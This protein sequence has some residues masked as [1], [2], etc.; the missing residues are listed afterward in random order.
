MLGP[1]RCMR[2]RRLAPPDSVLAHNGLHYLVGR[3]LEVHRRARVVPAAP[4]Y[5]DVPVPPPEDLGDSFSR[6][7]TQLPYQHYL[8]ELFAQHPEFV[9]RYAL[10]ELRVQRLRSREEGR[11]APPEG[12][13]RTG[14]VV[15]WVPARWGVEFDITLSTPRRTPYRPTPADQAVVS[16]WLSEEFGPPRAAGEHINRSV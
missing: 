12:G 13:L 7:P 6:L 15:E 5:I 16:H 3:N 1:A 11:R 14:P 4:Y 8:E 2:H 9:R 10:L